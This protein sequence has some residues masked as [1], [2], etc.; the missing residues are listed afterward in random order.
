MNWIATWRMIILSI[1]FGAGVGCRTQQCVDTPVATP[2]ALCIG[3]EW[4]FGLPPIDPDIVWGSTSKK[5]PSLVEPPYIN[6]MIIGEAFHTWLSGGE[7]DNVITEVDLLDA[8]SSDR[9][10]YQN[11][12]VHNWDGIPSP[13][14][15][16]N[17][18]HTCHYRA[19]KTPDPQ[20]YVVQSIDYPG[21]SQAWSDVMILQLINRP[22][23]RCHLGTKKMEKVSRLTLRCLGKLPDEIMQNESMLND[24]I[25][26]IGRTLL[27]TK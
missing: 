6:P 18:R 4:S 16:E 14:A 21:G 27:D 26:Q 2:A 9:F 7:F 13:R 17:N 19:F 22:F 20:I 11:F 8:D 3:Y 10:F 1:L 23:F 12:K 25:S 24:Y 5:L 15:E